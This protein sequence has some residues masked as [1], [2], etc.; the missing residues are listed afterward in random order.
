MA[1]ASASYTGQTVIYG[2]GENTGIIRGPPGGD[3]YSDGGY[4]G[5]SYGGSSYGGSISSGYG[6]SSLGGYGGSSYGSGSIISS[7]GYGGSSIGSS[8][9]GSSL[10]GSYGSGYETV[11]QGPISTQYHK[12][13]EARNWEVRFHDFFIVYKSINFFS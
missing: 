5:S 4:G 2:L 8:Y 12:Q 6:G 11:D 13:D 3:G 7:G 10:G 9:G 1:S